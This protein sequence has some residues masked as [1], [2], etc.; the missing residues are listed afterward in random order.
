MVHLESFFEFIVDILKSAFYTWRVIQPD[1]KGVRTLC[2]KNP[3]VLGPGLHLMWPVIGEI[4]VIPVK[5]QVLDV[6]SQSLTTRD[7]VSI[8]VGVSI[9]YEVS[10]P[11]RTVFEVQDWD[12]SLANEALRVIGEYVLSRT[13]EDCLDGP[14]MGTTILEGL[15]KTATRRW[16][17][18]ILRIGRTDFVRCPT[19]RIMGEPLVKIQPE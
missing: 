6:R 8:A 9:A 19:Y 13:Y 1:E 15:R 11:L 3:E 4:V 5:E 2:G 10:D 12:E 7:K 17:L 14:Q 18:K 16:G